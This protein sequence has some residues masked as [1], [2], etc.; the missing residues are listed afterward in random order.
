MR[1]ALAMTNQD[2]GKLAKENIEDIMALTPTQ[3]GMLYHYATMRD[4]RFYN[5]QL[6][7][8][9]TGPFSL[10][11]WRQAWQAT[12]D[13][14]E[15][16]RTVFRWKKLEHPVQIVLKYADIR[17]EEYDFATTEDVE[18][19]SLIEQVRERNRDSDMDIEVNPL[20]ISICKLD[21][22]TCEMIVNWHHILY[23][24]WSNGIILKEVMSAYESLLANEV[25]GIPK[26]TGFKQFVKWHQKQN[27]S[28]HRTYWERHLE[29]LSGA[30]SL[31]FEIDNESKALL[32]DTNRVVVAWNSSESMAVT[33]FTRNHAIT[34]AAFLYGVW[35]ILLHTYN[36]AIDVVFGTTVSGREPSIAG[37]EDVVGLFINTIPLRIAVDKETSTIDLFRRVE[38]SLR[39]RGPFENTPLVDI[40]RYGGIDSQSALF[41][42]IIVLENYPLDERIRG[43]RLVT[44]ES[45]LMHETTHYGL[46]LGIQTFGEMR[47]EI[48]YDSSRYSRNAV[49][50]I[51]GHFQRVVEQSIRRPEMRIASLDILSAEETQQILREFNGELREVEGSADQLVH[52]AFEEQARLTPNRVAVIHEGVSSTYAEL[53]KDANRMARRL[54]DSGI[55]PDRPVAIVLERSAAFV[56]AMLGVMKAGGCYIPI[57]H[58]FSSGRITQIIQDSGAEVLITRPEL[59]SDYRF[60]GTLIHPDDG[61]GYCEDSAD[62]LVNVN[63]SSDTAYIIYTSGSTGQPKGVMVAHRSLISFVRAFH[64][65]IRFTSEDVILQQASCSFDHFVEEVYPALLCGGTIVMVSRLDVLDV[66]RLIERIE[67]HAITVVTIQPLLLNELNRRKKL[68]RVHTYISGG[69]TLKYEHYSNLLAIANENEN[70]NTKVKVYNSYG[71]TEA[72]VCATYCELGHEHRKSVPI[73]RPITNSNVYIVD[74]GNRLKPIGVIGEIAISGSGV[75]KGYLHNRELTDRKFVQDP[76]RSGAVMYRTGDLGKWLEDGTLMFVGRNDEQIKVRGYR[77]EP[78]EIE[79]HLLNHPA[80]EEAVVLASNDTSGMKY[81]AA[82]IKCDPN[83]AASELREHLSNHLP[84]YMVPSL[85]NRL[86]YVPMTAN[87]K[88]DH[89]KLIEISEPLYNEAVDEGV[90]GDTEETIRGIWKRVLGREHVGLNDPFFE[91]GGNSLLLMQMHAR[92]EQE[93]ARGTSIVDLFTHPTIARL[94]KW[95]DDMQEERRLKD[96]WVNQSLPISHFLSRS[97]SSGNQVIRA[98]LSSGLHDQIRHLAAHNRVEGYDVMLSALLYLFTE[99]NGSAIATLHSLNEQG[100]DIVLLPID[101]TQQANFTDLFRYVHLQRMQPKMELRYPIQEASRMRSNIDPGVIWPL[102]YRQSGMGADTE[103]HETYELKL[104]IDDIAD[105]GRLSL[106]FSFNS[107][108]LR[109]EKMEVLLR[110]FVDLIQQLAGS[111]VLS[112]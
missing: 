30:A 62:N 37:V 72:T 10:A 103:W 8:R 46:T 63:D 38:E 11:A 3:A 55:A 84:H 58:D 71:P 33:E 28:E 80:V 78:R 93:Y 92:L 77:I 7:L 47:L 99:L 15:M 86:K 109:R 102:A 57:D 100:T 70:E 29:H 9:I 106:L 95:I 5:Q 69:D 73:G 107:N 1:G 32:E 64:M 82:Y 2:S 52:L 67:D 81:L 83:V 44:V 89:K 26:K 76:Y 105:D 79:I 53:N 104:G 111:H 87:A 85:F 112:G 49:E 19:N 50:R 51:T 94:A 97:Q 17:L 6:S 35:G 101:M 98:H 90:A 74:D 108:R 39:L 21:E 14:N 65:R 43:G 56:S 22:R 60:T 88:A 61:I 20:F 41:D 110:D 48:S 45:Y 59:G 24:G 18:K 16:L 91:I 13:A 25:S 96:E 23:D 31:P 40:A 4:R 34:A 66:N 36:D 68:P 27:K 75:A 42:S 54:R 12:V